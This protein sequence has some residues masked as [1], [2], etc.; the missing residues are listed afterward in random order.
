MW[1]TTKLKREIIIYLKKNLNVKVHNFVQKLFHLSEI[2]PEIWKGCIATQTASK[3]FL[4][5]SHELNEL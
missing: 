3:Y 2:K 5:N 4:L 1:A